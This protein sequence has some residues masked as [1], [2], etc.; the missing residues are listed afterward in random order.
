MLRPK[1]FADL[2]TYIALRPMERPWP[3]DQPQNCAVLSMRNIMDG[4]SP[5]LMVSHDDDDHGW[6][7]LDGSEQPNAADAVMVCL[8]HV[9]AH[10]P[11]L[12]ELC[13]L[14]PGWI[15]Y[16]VNRRANWERQKVEIEVDE[17]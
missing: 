8:S 7:F 11:S 5:I 12:Y 6:Q 9:L 17:P 13:D 2:S 3:F 16:R 10:D 14:P 4:T 1:E 15:A